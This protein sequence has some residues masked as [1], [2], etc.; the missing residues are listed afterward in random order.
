[1]ASSQTL[2]G[3]PELFDMVMIDIFPQQLFMI[4]RVCRTWREYITR[5]TKLQTHMFLRLGLPNTDA[6]DVEINPML[7]TMIRCIAFK[8]QNPDVAHKVIPYSIWARPECSLRKTLLVQQPVEVSRLS[9]MIR[10]ITQDRYSRQQSFVRTKGYDN[11]FNVTLE[12][13][14]ADMVE[15]LEVD[16]LFENVTVYST[17]VYKDGVWRGDTK[18]ATDHEKRHRDW[19]LRRGKLP[20]L[21]RVI[22]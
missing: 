13:V 16:C 22:A 5:S 20:D 17:K 6:A 4:R 10:M 18:M 3:I 12:T 8:D 11:N 21:P 14:A 1:M 19:I 9:I 15:L 7:A 2:F